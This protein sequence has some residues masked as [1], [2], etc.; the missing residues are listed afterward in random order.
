MA[1][2]FAAVL[3]DQPSSAAHRN[4]PAG[5]ERVIQRCLTKDPAERFQTAADLGFAL[6]SL[7]GDSGSAAPVMRSAPAGA[8]IAVLPF[9]DMSATRDQDWLCDGLA[10]ELINVLS[11]I[12][13]LRV[14]A[15]SSSFQFR[16]SGADI[17]AVGAKLGVATVL[18]GGVRRSPTVCA[19]P[20]SS[21]KS[22]AGTSAGRSASTAKSPMSSPSRTRSPSA[23]RPRSA[24]SS[25]RASAK[26][27]RRPETAMEAYEYFLRGRQ[28]LHQFQKATLDL[29]KTMFERAIEI[30]PT[31][32]P[33]WAGLADTHSW[34]FEWWGSRE[35]DLEMADRASRR[36]L[37]LSPELAES[38]ASR[39]FR[40][41]STPAI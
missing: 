29:A 11:R 13:G 28:R 32:A 5:L 37:E 16:S 39:G 10:D 24:A 19:S 20:S 27:L 34:F 18:E 3:H 22:R 36:A 25:V 26:R 14:A 7:G 17:Q 2:T 31:Y 40:P 41:L 4:V 15:R 23:S 6:D 9:A 35:A 21:S 30:D 33:A 12:D 8:S 38:H 1:E